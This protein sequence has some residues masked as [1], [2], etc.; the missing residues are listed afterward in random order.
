[1]KFPY[2]DFPGNDIER[3]PAVTSAEC[4]EKCVA[5]DNCKGFIVYGEDDFPDST[6]R[7]CWLKTLVDVNDPKPHSYTQSYFRLKGNS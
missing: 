5:N 2:T 1:M 3:L 4:A 7:S 6:K